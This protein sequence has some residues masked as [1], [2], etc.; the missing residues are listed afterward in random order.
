MI[1]HKYSSYEQHFNYFI[2]V[3]F[4]LNFLDVRLLYSYVMFPCFSRLLRVRL[5]LSIHAKNTPGAWPN[6]SSQVRCAQFVRGLRLGEF[7]VARIRARARALK[8]V[9][10]KSGLLDDLLPLGKHVFGFI[11]KEEE[12]EEADEQKVDDGK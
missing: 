9:L 7:S 1:N 11:D 12:V 4:T 10:G 6:H 5:R 8:E 2:E 3:K